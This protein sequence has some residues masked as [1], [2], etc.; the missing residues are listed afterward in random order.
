MLWLGET[1]ERERKGSINKSWI[2]NEVEKKIRDFRNNKQH[3]SALKL[4]PTRIEHSPANN[5]KK[6]RE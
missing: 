6:Y 2:S 3:L 1:R 4:E 5:E